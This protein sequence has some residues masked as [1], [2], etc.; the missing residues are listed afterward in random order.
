MKELLR[1]WYKKI[2]QKMNYDVHK[3]LLLNGKILSQ[4]N[5]Q[6]DTIKSL[7]EV[8][9]QVFSQRGEDGVLQYLISKIDIPNK[10]FIEFGVETYTESN[11]RF[12]LI[13]DN[14]SGLVIDGSEKNIDFIKKDFI[15]WKYDITAKKSFITKDNI[16][17]LISSYTDIKDIGLLSVDIDG[18]DYWVWE[19]INCINPRIVVCEYNSAYGPEKKLTIP[20]KENFV[21]NIEHYSELYFGASL[22]AFCDLAEKKGYQFVGTTSAGVNAYFVRND[23]VRPFNTYTAKEG[24]NESA[25]RDSKTKEGKLSFLRHSERLKLIEEM[26]IFDIDENRILKIKEAFKTE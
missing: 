22:A 3:A 10:I 19:A 15:Y 6:K 24:F 12:L 14:W 26:P 9:F 16:D 25:N 11:T 4:L 8:E 23:L 7:D 2:Y 21:R 5:S 17:D 13:N 18:N 20:Y 1:F